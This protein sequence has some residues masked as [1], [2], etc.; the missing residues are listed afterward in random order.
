MGK[1][2]VIAE[3]PSVARDIAAVLKCGEKGDGFIGG[4][5][6]I[7]SW[8][9]GHLVTLCE[10]DDY[11]KSLK[12]WTA[13]SLPIIPEKMKLKAVRGSK[14]Q[15]DTLKKLMNAKDTDSIISVSYTHL[16]GKRRKCRIRGNC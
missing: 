12:R 2:L 15:L 5:N 14:K 10:P 4:E 3:K 6:Y 11:D 9:V 1:V 16:G 8:A 7:V 13:G